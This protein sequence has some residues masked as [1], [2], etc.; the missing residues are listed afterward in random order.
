LRQT[1]V[2]TAIGG[3]SGD[4]G[5]GKPRAKVAIDGDGGE[6]GV[7]SRGCRKPAAVERREDA[8]RWPAPA[9]AAI[10]GVGEA[11]YCQLALAD[12]G[13]GDHLRRIGGE[14]LPTARLMKQ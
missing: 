8:W 11:S 12:A 3:D 9:V 6:S 13:S 4:A 14:T 7:G 1:P 10:G 5:C 2:V